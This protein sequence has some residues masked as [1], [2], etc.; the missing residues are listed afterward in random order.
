MYG[1]PLPVTEI[2]SIFY[3]QIMFVSHSKHTY[4]PSR[5]VTEIALL[6]KM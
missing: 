1:P 4:G 5:P 6:F 2:A 3:M